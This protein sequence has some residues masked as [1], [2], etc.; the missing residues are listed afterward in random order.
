MGFA[1]RFRGG[2]A[3]VLVGG[4]HPTKLNYRDEWRDTRDEEKRVSM[5]PVVAFMQRSVLNS[6][7]P[8]LNSL[9]LARQ[10]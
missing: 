4:A 7:G 6:V 5:H 1:H 10:I 3:F 8:N 2:D 9:A